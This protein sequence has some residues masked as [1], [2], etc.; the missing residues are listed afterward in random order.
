MK[1]FTSTYLRH[2][3]TLPVIAGLQLLPV[4]SWAQSLP[5]GGVVS[6][7]AAQIGAPSGPSLQ[8]NQTSQRAVIN[9]TGFGI[10]QGNSVNFVQPN[11]AASTLNIVTGS[12]PSVIAGRMTA[13]GSVFLINQNGIAI[14]P[15]G[16][17]DTRTGFVASTLG[18]DQNDFMSGRLRFAGKGARVSNEGQILS[19]EN[20]MVALLGS[21]VRND[22]L[23]RAPLG[24]VGLGSGEAVTLD[25]NGDGFLQ[26]SVPADTVAADGQP[27]V[28]N[29]GSIVADGGSVILRASAVRAA[30]R[31]AV[32]MP[33][34]IQARS[35][36][37]QNGAVVLDG[38][39]GTLQLSGKVDVAGLEADSSGGRIDVSAAQVTLAG[40]QL[41]A[42][43]AVQGGLVRIGGTYQGGRQSDDADSQAFVGRFGA[44]PALAN[45]S[46]VAVDAGSR[47]DVSS[48]AGAGGT[49]IVSS[50]DKTTMAG[51]VDASSAKGG[52]VAEIGSSQQIAA[53]GLGRIKLGQ[54]STLLL[55]ANNIYIASQD[56]GYAGYSYLP[57]KEV[58]ALLGSGAKLNVQARDKLWWDNNS[59]SNQVTAGASSPAGD[60]WLMAGNTVTLSG[61][62]HSGG[63]NW[64]IYADYLYNG[65]GS[66]AGAPGKA[67]I[68]LGSAA[69]DLGAGEL[70]LEMID[71]G[72][73]SAGMSVGSVSAGSLWA[74]IGRT[75][76][77]NP[78]TVNFT[79][80]I[81]VSGDVR[82]SGDLRVT[83]DFQNPI[84]IRGHSVVWIDESSAT[85]SGEGRIAFIENGVTTRLGALSDSGVAARLGLGAD[86]AA[87][88][89]YGDAEPTQADLGQGGLRVLNDTTSKYI[90]ARDTILAPGSLALT[91]PGKQAPVGQYS[92]SLT[93]TSD[94]WF[95]P[96]RTYGSYWV[97]LAP[98]T[99][100]LIITP[101]PLGVQ[102]GTGLTTYG[103]AVPMVSLTNVVS[104][105]QIFPVAS[106][107][108]QQGIAMSPIG[109]AFGFDARHPAGSY[110]YTVTGF[111]GAQNSNYV[112]S[113][114]SML[115]G[116]LQIDPKQLL[117]SVQGGGKTYGTL[118]D[119][120]MATLDGVLPGDDVRPAL[121]LS[122][123]GVAARDDVRLPA[124][125]YNLTLDSLVGSAAGN[126]A[127]T[128]IGGNHADVQV[129]PA[130]LQLLAKDATTTYGDTPVLGATS[131]LV[132]GDQV[133][134]T[135]GVSANGVS[136]TPSAKTPAGWYQ[137]AITGISGP[138]AGNYIVDYAGGNGY[139]S[140]RVLQRTLNYQGASISQIYGQP[141]LPGPAL[142]GVLGDDNVRGVNVWTKPDGSPG[143]TAGI[144]NVGT[145]RVMPAELAGS[146]AGNYVLGTGSP[147]TVQVTPKTVSVRVDP[148]KTIY[149]TVPQVFPTVE[150]LVGNDI[151]TASVDVRS[152]FANALTTTVP[153]GNYSLG[154]QAYLAGPAAGNYVLAPDD[155]RLNVPFTVQPKPL[156]WDAS[157]NTT[158]TY[159]DAIGATARLSGVLPGDQVGAMT[160]V[161]D[162]QGK[163]VARPDAG[164][165]LL[166]ATAL[167][168]A[169]A[170]NYTLSTGDNGNA[171]GNL[172]VNPRPVT[173]DAIG[174]TT[175][176]YGNTPVF[177]ELRYT[178]VLKGDDPGLV[179]GDLLQNNSGFSAHTPVGTYSASVLKL[180]NP[181][182]VLGVQDPVAGTLSIVPRPMRFSTADAS[183]VY[184]D[185]LPS[186][187]A[188]LLDD[189]VAGDDLQI[190]TVLPKGAADAG[191]VGAGQYQ[192]MAGLLGRSA[193]NYEL[194]MAG[195]HIGQL[196]VAKRPL[197]I[198]VDLFANQGNA[199]SSDFTGTQRLYRLDYGYAQ[200]ITP[201]LA[202]FNLAAGDK[203]D[204]AFT[205]PTLQLSSTSNVAAGTYQWTVY[206]LKDPV[207]ANYDVR[208]RD[209]VLN[210]QRAPLYVTPGALRPNGTVVGASA[211]YGSTD[212]LRG[213]AASM[214]GL[215][216]NV[217]KQDD[218]VASFDFATASGASPTLF[219]RSPA[220]TYTLVNGALRGADAANY[221]FVART[222]SFVVEPKLVTI[223]APDFYTVYGKALPTD[224]APTISGALPGD[225]LGASYRMQDGTPWETRLDAGAYRF[226]PTQLT[227][228]DAANY[229]FV[230]VDS[231]LK[232][233]VPN[234]PD[235]KYGNLYVDKVYLPS[236]ID[237][238]GL[239]LIYGGYAPEITLQKP[240]E[241][242]QVTVDPVA[243]SPNWEDT[244]LSSAISTRALLDAGRYDY[245]ATLSGRDAHNYTLW[246]GES[247]QSGNTQ[248]TPR[249]FS[250]G[251]INVQKRELTT[252]V[253]DRTTAYGNYV[254][255][256]SVVHNLV[257]GQQVGVVVTTT[258]A[259]GGVVD[260][261]ERT[262]TGKYSATVTALT[263]DASR[264]YTLTGS[265]TA[266]L[267]IVPR[268]L[269]WVPVDAPT[270]I[271]GE[272]VTLG[273]LRGLLFNDDV[274]VKGSVA[275]P[276]GPL[277]LG[278][279]GSGATRFDGKLDVGS[280]GYSFASTDNLA[281]A[282]SANYVLA[283]GASGSFSLTTREVVY[284][285]DNALG[286]YGNFK[287]CERDCDPW[288]PG[289][290]LGKPHFQALIDGHRVE[291]VVAGDDLGGTVGVLDFNGV[292]TTIDSK[293]PVGSYFEVLTGL[294]GK[295]AS[296][297]RLAKTGSAPGILTIQ[298]MWL[299]Y[300]VSNTI[301]IK[302]LGQAGDL[303]KV[304]LRGPD[305]TPINGDQVS[306]DGI[307]LRKETISWM[308]YPYYKQEPVPGRYEAYAAG[309]TGKDAGNY[310]LY[311]GR[312]ANAGTYGRNVPGTIDV[313]DNLNLGLDF[314]S[315]I[316]LPVSPKTTTAPLAAPE[317]ALSSGPTV[318]I[319]E[320][321]GFSYDIERT[322]G[323][324]N[325][326][327]SLANA[328]VSGE[329]SGTTGLGSADLSGK[330]SGAT[331]ALA[332]AGITGISLA[333]SATGKTEVMV[334]IG[335][336]YVTYGVQG[337]VAAE[338]QLG[339][340]GL[341]LSAEAK[342]Q[343]AATGGAKGSLGA[344]GDGDVSATAATFVFAKAENT[345]GLKN[346]K[347]VA[348][349]KNEVGGGASAGV[350][351]EISGAVGSVKLGATVYSPGS[352]GAE[353]GATAGYSD[354][355]V[356]IGL[357][358]GGTFG[359]G[360][361]SLNL[362]ISLD[363]S[364]VSDFF[365][366]IFGHRKD[367]L[368]RLEDSFGMRDNP[369]ARIAY[370]NEHPEWRKAPGYFSD[371][372]HADS[373]RQTVEF[374][375]DYYRLIRA[376][377]DLATDEAAARTEFLKLVEKDPAAAVKYSHDSDRFEPL[378]SRE[379]GV[380]GLAMHL[381]IK[382]VV[383]N[384]T[385]SFANE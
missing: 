285:V 255:P 138:D 119:K 313:Y 205:N 8:V 385:V 197:D 41:D 365:S 227:G 233:R 79:K 149:G 96:A 97:D 274:S 260:Y 367:P 221:D 222:G 62:F 290:E 56:A 286:S 331:E 323:E 218:V 178:N 269:G 259:N 246:I 186:G 160:G 144:F 201:R 334:T 340:D 202:M 65:I 379:A 252:T 50:T 172:T 324:S 86:A 354:G 261:N 300:S 191:R 280:Y 38:G 145:Y 357:N 24:K 174:K 116:R 360:G 39:D 69:L 16:L 210:V 319:L 101:R 213:G 348:T 18:M 187:G 107:G 153:A 346:G 182:Y 239:T 13:N 196:S 129:V 240:L 242:D 152:G 91:G 143:A 68:N 127:L 158:I 383:D 243:R 177:A 220:G 19:G 77:T 171:Q 165:H 3:F 42:H 141:N 216:G 271:Y 373:Y 114:G 231:P 4:A 325:A 139:G 296:N 155:A 108:T 20:G 181:N 349:S 78:A 26:V 166:S 329:A 54:G 31:D 190:G 110:T 318:S 162:S 37:G 49:A 137:T 384:G 109:G 337:D 176:A 327:V 371:A 87:T 369:L 228:A 111:D 314:V 287:G 317:P 211:E 284:A 203:V 217:G 253:A 71:R 320:P 17:V 359:L 321:E 35:V 173:I 14:T 100:P 378:R 183:I 85:I 192:L 46:T 278:N 9:W 363:F 267:D 209:S 298:P 83:G 10:G 215:K 224:L 28:A 297:Y 345:Y 82:F 364:A 60:L 351:G 179:L 89:I 123:N 330:A 316:P 303:G 72:G 98:A 73:G 11:S 84:K 185:L 338:A 92:M 288:V 275:G 25:L 88:R 151:V 311:S 76:F 163:I 344:A 245:T 7:G 194:E 328:T 295:S 353:F 36:S 370:L 342:A 266:K 106:I 48:S 256:S 372:A 1:N 147:N 356:S 75:T 238:S 382:L 67:Y 234:L 366:S 200:T 47:I 198:S 377:Q 170:G 148:L 6:A 105:D 248:L 380:Y 99:A 113:P 34:T 214:D 263:G 146:D 74:G 279:G 118:F 81:T 115:E 230:D 310:R 195:S 206:N 199:L 117:A 335:P 207:L 232:A 265:N 212:R 251:M 112:L 53:T 225:R 312:I 154:L 281:G 308:Y 130:R 315:H 258:A 124:G 104:G 44:L 180:N 362:D 135:F 126:Y 305:G 12:D 237:Q 282:K 27:L 175:I 374:V 66:A 289:V 223:Q 15:T 59:A 63:G 23:I 33:G 229:R 125:T 341:E 264:N 355:K 136:F 343:M 307:E 134:V 95:A 30:M 292:S 131:P 43:G 276:A 102:A 352:L 291:G 368:D 250:Y 189:A 70:D 270:A 52:G 133:D 381:G 204:A 40:A 247:Y 120:P 159:G 277:A 306:S 5:T 80:D 358:L 122:K 188:K 273:G 57:D 94:A 132:P 29:N 32:N 294:T 121:T 193:S 249:P 309:L 45:A 64:G 301:Y 93:A 333:A 299:S 169:N 55:D 235:T 332:K 375:D 241:G 326:S 262:D 157:G 103:T 376:V 161:L 156:F 208:V 336:G 61:S 128:L 150:G 272:P 304:T 90:D 236:S 51:A 21:T 22:G 361:F 268:E 226:V 283:K 293:T 347:I 219:E 244:P 302:G 339:K 164:A 168:G 142:L 322:N 184:G 167:S 254:A 350:T 257:P 140:W 2:T 58:T